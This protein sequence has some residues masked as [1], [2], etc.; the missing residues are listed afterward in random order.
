[1]NAKQ[2]VIGVGLLALLSGI[3]AVSAPG[4]GGRSVYGECYRL[5][6]N[7]CLKDDDCEA[8]GTAPT[9]REECAANADD[10]CD[11][12]AQQIEDECG[13]FDDVDI[14]EVSVDRCVGSTQALAAACRAKDDDTVA[15]ETG[16]VI[17]DCLDKFYSCK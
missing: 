15:N 6:Y 2:G 7:A 4:C 5:T 16:H 14:D 11:T 12:R 13:S 9:D 1:M 8:Y 3:V 10:F 17:V